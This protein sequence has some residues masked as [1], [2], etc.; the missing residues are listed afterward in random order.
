MLTFPLFI[1]SSRRGVRFE[2]CGFL[3]N[4]NFVIYIRK[5]VLASGSICSFDYVF[6]LLKCNKGFLVAN[7][8]LAHILGVVVK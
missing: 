4:N 8:I 6:L 2:M 3:K 7:Y 5:F 1:W